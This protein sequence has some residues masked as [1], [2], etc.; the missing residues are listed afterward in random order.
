LKYKI[1]SAETEYE[2]GSGDLVLRNKLAIVSEADMNEAE[3]VL[4]LKLYDKVFDEFATMT[5]GFQTICDWHRQWLGPIYDWAGMLRAVNM[6]KGGFPFTA[7]MV[8]PKA[9]HEFENKYLNRFSELSEL[10]TEALV[11]FLAESHVEFILAHPFREGNGRISRLLMDVMATEAG[12]GPL[13][14]ALFDKHKD[15]YFKSIQAGLEGDTQY[16]E[17]LVRDTLARD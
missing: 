5:L 6:S 17:R 16:L 11:S 15:F 7:A 9:A 1:D 12:I 13:D 14:Y 4:L 3:E 2:P 10:N 8:L